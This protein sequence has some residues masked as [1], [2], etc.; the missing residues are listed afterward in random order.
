MAFRKVN[1]QQTL[2]GFFARDIGNQ[3]TGTVVKYV[4]MKNGPFFVV[5][6]TKDCKVMV[7]DPRTKKVKPGVAV[8]MQFIGVSAVTTL[9]PVKDLVGKLVRLTFKGTVPSK[10]FVGKEISLFDI[11]V[12]E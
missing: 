2:S 9:G 11:E 5:E 6:L 4:D 3:A 10:K 7:Q 8:P 1:E 12:D